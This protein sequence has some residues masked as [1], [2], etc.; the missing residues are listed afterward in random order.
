MRQEKWPGGRE[1]K[2]L[3][4]IDQMPVL[5]LLQLLS[6][7]QAS[8]SLCQLAPNPALWACLVWLL[9]LLP[10]PWNLEHAATIAAID[11][12]VLWLKLIKSHFK[13]QDGTNLQQGHT[14]SI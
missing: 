13:V 10:C 5:L 8:L 2:Y 9:L 11:L 14:L 4:T 12:H 6:T 3:L 7:T 1:T